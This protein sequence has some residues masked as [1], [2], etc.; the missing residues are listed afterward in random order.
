MTSSIQKTSQPTAL[1]MLA[2]TA[3]WE[4]FSYYGMRA[5][6]ILYMANATTNKLG[7]MGW[8]TENSGMIYG[9]FTGLCYLFPLFGGWIADRFIAERRSVLIGGLFI[10]IG[11]FT[12][13]IDNGVVP[14]VIGLTLL[15]IGNGFFKPT[16]VTM[17]GDLYEQGDPRRDVGFTQYYMI[18]NFA[19]FFAPILCGFF[20]ETYGFR[21]GFMTAGFAMA[22]GLLIYLIFARK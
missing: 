14:F 5:F 19:V 3:S 15:I 16:I 13:A 22:F 4:R 10:M 6:L 18:F 17:V 1:Y 2:L 12:C 11:H 20:G 8:S 7:G 9:I 21:Y